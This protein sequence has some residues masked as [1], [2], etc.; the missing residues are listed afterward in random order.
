LQG[1]RANFGARNGAGGFYLG[2]LPIWFGQLSG[3]ATDTSVFM[4]T[5]GF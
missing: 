1:W 5:S 4:G 2:K 3:Q